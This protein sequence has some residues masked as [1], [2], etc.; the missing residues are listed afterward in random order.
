METCTVNIGIHTTYQLLFFLGFQ[1]C[2]LLRM[3]VY[4]KLSTS[5]THT[6]DGHKFFIFMLLYLLN[7]LILLY[8]VFLIK[9][10]Q[11]CLFILMLF[12]SE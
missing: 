10:I 3:C 12:I 11:Q 1:T 7:I 5:Q 4:L 9:G 8:L 2:S 6:L